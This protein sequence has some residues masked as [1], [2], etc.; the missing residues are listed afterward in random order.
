MGFFRRRRKAEPEQDT[1]PKV[2]RRGF[3]RWP[4]KIIPRPIKASHRKTLQLTTEFFSADRPQCPDC[5][6]EGRDGVLLPVPN[7][8]NIRKCSDPDCALTITLREL[9]DINGEQV[10]YVPEARKAYFER[11]ATILFVVG[12]AVL[13]G[14]VLYSGWRGS[15]SMMFA[16]FLLSMPVF[17]GAFAMRYRAWQVSENRFYEEKAPLGEFV[18]A[19]LANLFRSGNRS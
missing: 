13:S 10:H 6:A 8:P 4:G 17:M 18:Q 16:A 19:E 14:A 1:T 7:R 9:A 3:L 2:D 11:W 12:C 15:G 5:R